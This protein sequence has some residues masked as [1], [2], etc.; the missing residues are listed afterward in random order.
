MN[1]SNIAPESVVSIQAQELEHLK[2]VQEKYEKLIEQRRA[3]GNKSYKKWR[4][5]V[6]DNDFKERRK[7]ANAKYRE[8]HKEKIKGYYQKR[9]QETE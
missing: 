7:L 5:N 3:I 9:K 2:Q 6:D 8:T 1:V 4:E